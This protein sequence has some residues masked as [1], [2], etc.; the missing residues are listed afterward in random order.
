MARKPQKRTLET[1]TRIVDRA[2]TL[3]QNQGFEAVSMEAIAQESGVAKGTLF[4]HFGDK[5]GLMSLLVAEQLVAILD[6]WP[7]DMRFD[8]RYLEVLHHHCM[9]LIDLL[10]SDRIVLQ[11]Y[12]DFSGTTSANRSEEFVAVL[13]GLD[14]RLRSHMNDWAQSQDCLRTDL[15]V[16]T[17]SDGVAAFVTTAAL[18]RTCGIIPDRPHCADKLMEQFHGWLL[19]SK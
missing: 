1:R 15:S 4:A 13:D 9:T 18:Y 7:A 12:L 17:L 10:C 14:A 3:V 11:I 2:R 16:D 6:D 19:P 8:G 5:N